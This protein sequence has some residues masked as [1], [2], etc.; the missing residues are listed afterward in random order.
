ME[1]YVKYINFKFPFILGQRL[2]ESLL[3]VYWLSPQGS[4]TENAP[5]IYLGYECEND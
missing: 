2:D 5:D 1:Y 4:F 3:S